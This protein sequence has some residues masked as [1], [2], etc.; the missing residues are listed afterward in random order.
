MNEALLPTACGV[1]AV[2]L[3]LA[4]QLMVGRTTT[5]CALMAD[6]YH[7]GGVTCVPARGV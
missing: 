7:V 2:R 4:K 6:W 3:R 1:R 5:L